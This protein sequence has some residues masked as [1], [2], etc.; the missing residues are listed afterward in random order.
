MCSTLIGANLTTSTSFSTVIGVSNED[1]EN[2]IFIVGNGDLEDVTKKSNALIL[3]THGNLTVS[4][5]VSNSGEDYAEYFEWADSN[6]L[7]EDRV[8]Y[9]VTLQ[10]DKICKAQP[11]D[12]ILGIISGTACVIGDE[13]AYE[14]K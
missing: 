8:G 2:G 14:W 9:I 13:A 3:D 6:I 4:G 10:E 7:N 5:T 12:D 1:I 11:G